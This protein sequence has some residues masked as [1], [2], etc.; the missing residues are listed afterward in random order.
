[1][2]NLFVLHN[3]NDIYNRKMNSQ[4]QHKNEFTMSICVSLN[5]E[6]IYTYQSNKTELRIL[7][8]IEHAVQPRP[9][10]IGKVQGILSVHRI[11][12]DN[13]Q[14]SGSAVEVGRPHHLLV[15]VAGAV[16]LTVDAQLRGEQT[17]A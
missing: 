17:A 11:L 15:T 13:G 10:Q 5:T 7:N 4:C 1:M 2:H 14:A 8:N 12:T 3:S 6:H 16:H 9:V